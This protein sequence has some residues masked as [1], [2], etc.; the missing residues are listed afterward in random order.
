MFQILEVVCFRSVLQGAQVFEGA[1]PFAGVL[2][3]EAEP[4]H[5]FRQ[6]AAFQGAGPEAMSR[7]GEG[8][9]NVNQACKFQAW[10]RDRACFC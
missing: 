4:F 5:V 7:W 1:Q 3:F 10:Q 2:A 6:T 8:I 9:Y